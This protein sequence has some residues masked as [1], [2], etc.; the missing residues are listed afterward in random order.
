MESGDFDIPQGGLP[1]GHR[2][3]HSNLNRKENPALTRRVR[4]FFYPHKNFPWVL[5]ENGVV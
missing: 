3:F 4:A 5:G 1:S 2:V